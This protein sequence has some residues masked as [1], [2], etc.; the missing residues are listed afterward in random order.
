MPDNVKPYKSKPEFKKAQHIVEFALIAPFIIFFIGIVLEIAMI[1][2]TNYKFN[3][4]LYEAISFMALNNKI[5]VDKE[6]TVQNIKEY[7]KILLKHR[8]VPYKDSLDTELVQAGDLDF[9]IGKYRYTSTFT[10]FNYMTGYKPDSYNFLTII[11][12]NSAILR[13][14]SFDLSNETVENLMEAYYNTSKE[15]EGAIEGENGEESAD[16]DT[17]KNPDKDIDN[18]V[19]SEGGDESTQE[20]SEADKEEFDVQIP[21]VSLQ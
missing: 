17:G 5:G 9:I 6:D 4:S 10:L 7:A 21:E 16:S 19:E 20:P 13:K 3:A 11:P 2:Q 8:F 12:I 15:N 18:N 14:N 1:V